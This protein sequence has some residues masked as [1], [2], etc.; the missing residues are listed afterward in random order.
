M[1]SLSV[2]IPVYNASKYLCRSVDSLMRQTLTE[3]IEFIFVNDASTDDSL[4]VLRKTIDLFPKRR[5]QVKIINL[6]KNS[7]V[8][9]A[10]RAGM[11]A[12]QGEFLIHCDSDDWVDEDLYEKM[13]AGQQQKDADVVTA[14]FC[15]EFGDSHKVERF[16]DTQS[17]R[18]SLARDEW[19]TLWSKMVRRSLIEKYELYPVDGY[20]YME[21]VWVLMRAFFYAQTIAFVHNAFYHY[22]RS[23]ELSLMHTSLDPGSLRKRTENLIRIEQFFADK[24]DMNVSGFICR[25]KLSYRDM[26]LSQ[27][28]IDFCN[29]RKT[30]PESVVYLVNSNTSG[31]TYKLCYLLAHMGFTMPLRLILH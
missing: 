25:H 20:N 17:P 10:R 24:P 21:D 26:Y 28:P 23:N 27:R 5:E 31:F 13:L 9:C 14:D 19:W 15:H 4:K 8:A 7:G 1:I 11:M 12:A 29:W 2:I 6:E 3:G 16:T 22:N 18:E 30:F